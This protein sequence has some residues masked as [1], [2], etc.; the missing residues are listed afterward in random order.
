LSDQ[1]R[2]RLFNLPGVI[3]WLIVAMGALHF[4]RQHFLTNE[5]DV[6]LLAAFSSCPHD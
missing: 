2:E 5:D 4:F 3:L 1:P 6:A